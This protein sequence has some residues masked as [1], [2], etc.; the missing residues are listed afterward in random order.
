MEGLGILWG[1][2]RVLEGFYKGS[3]LVQGLWVRR[4]GRRFGIF[5]AWSSG[6]NH[7]FYYPLKFS[8]VVSTRVLSVITLGFVQLLLQL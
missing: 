1:F 8:S 6:S 4:L 2:G 3:K 7:L 5:R